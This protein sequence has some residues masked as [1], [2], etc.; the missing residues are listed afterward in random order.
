MITLPARTALWS[1]Q[2]DGPRR[3]DRNEGSQHRSEVNP[4]APQQDL[5][6][7]EKPLSWDAGYALLEQQVPTVR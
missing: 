7:R 2:D 5:R 3:E 1:P 6:N 4:P